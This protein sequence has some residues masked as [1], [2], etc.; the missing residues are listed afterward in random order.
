MLDDLHRGC[1]TL[2]VTARKAEQIEG[3]I[4]AVLQ[5]ERMRMNFVK[6]FT[7]PP[8]QI[9]RNSQLVH[10][11]GFNLVETQAKFCLRAGSIEFTLSFSRTQ[12]AG[13]AFLPCLGW[14]S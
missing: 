3:I 2:F 8:Q 5:Q 14:R 11:P 9:F 10:I 4:L 6:N 13:Y 12:H 7:D 1:C